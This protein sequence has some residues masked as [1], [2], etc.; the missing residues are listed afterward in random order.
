MRRASL[1]FTS[2]PYLPFTHY[3]P[4]E[5]GRTAPDSV[6]WARSA[7]GRPFGLFGCAATQIYMHV[8][9]RLARDTKQAVPKLGDAYALDTASPP[10]SLSPSVYDLLYAHA[11][12]EAVCA[13]LPLPAPSE[14]AANAICL[15]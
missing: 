14:A 4:S 12:A 3:S 8:R 11:L 10:A 6:R 9:S 2:L 15:P 5:G 7:D 13:V 1:R